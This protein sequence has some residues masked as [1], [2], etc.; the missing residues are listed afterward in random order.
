MGAQFFA[1]A[2]K[3]HPGIPEEMRKGKFDT[4]HAWLIEN[5]YKWGRKYTA[6]ELIKRVT[7]GEVSIEPYIN[8]LR[9]KYGELY[10]L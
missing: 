9:T 3:A 5:I 2:L 4:L 10:H 7:G 6:P 8:Y 1:E